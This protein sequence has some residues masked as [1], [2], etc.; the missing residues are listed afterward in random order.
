VTTQSSRKKRRDGKTKPEQLK[1][2]ID[3]VFQ[4]AE[5]VL[6]IVRTLLELLHFGHTIGLW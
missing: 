1:K 2:V 4:V 6:V 3:R 5:V